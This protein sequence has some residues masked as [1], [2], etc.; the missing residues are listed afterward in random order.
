MVHLLVM[1]VLI[2]YK[3]QEILNILLLPTLKKVHTEFILKIL[4]NTKQKKKKEKMNKFSL[5]GKT[6]D[7]YCND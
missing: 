5:I 7:I 6:G 1:A 3:D 2:W 4:V